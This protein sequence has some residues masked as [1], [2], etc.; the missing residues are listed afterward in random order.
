MP[1]LYIALLQLSNIFG[2]LFL[3]IR[4]VKFI[5]LYKISKTSSMDPRLPELNWVIKLF[6]CCVFPELLAWNVALGKAD[7]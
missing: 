5:Y 4:M 7:C 2:W 1:I 3:Y 6:D